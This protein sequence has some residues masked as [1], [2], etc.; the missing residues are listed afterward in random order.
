MHIFCQMET[1]YALNLSTFDLHYDIN[2]HVLKSD[3]YTDVQLGLVSQ[4]AL[5]LKCF[6][7]GNLNLHGL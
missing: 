4:L 3:K 6:E 5:G 2:P 7:V 1:G